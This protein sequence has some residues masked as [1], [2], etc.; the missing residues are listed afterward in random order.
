VVCAL[1]V[2]LVNGCAQSAQQCHTYVFIDSLLEQPRTPTV[3][4]F[5]PFNIPS[6]A[7]PFYGMDPAVV[8]SGGATLRGSLTDIPTIS[9]ALNPQNLKLI[10]EVPEYQYVTPVAG[11]KYP[12]ASVEV[13]VAG[14]DPLNASLGIFC[15]LTGHSD[16]ETKR[17][18]FLDLNKVYDPEVGSLDF[19]LIEE[20][21]RM[22]SSK[23]KL[24]S[25]VLRSGHQENWGVTDTDVTFLRDPFY[26]VLQDEI[27]PDGLASHTTFVHLFLNGQYWGLY[28]LAERPDDK[29]AAN[30]MG[31]DNSEYFAVNGGKSFAEKQAADNP[32]KYTTLFTQVVAQNTYLP[33]LS[34]YVDVPR[35]YDYLLL[36]WYIGMND[37]P[38]K[39]YWVIY[40]GV[41][42]NSAYRY[43]R[44]VAWDGEV[45]L[46]SAY[47]RCCRTTKTASWRCCSRTAST[48]PSSP[49]PSPK[50]AARSTR[51]TSTWSSPT[52]TGC[53][54]RYRSSSRP[55]PPPR[56]STARTPRTRTR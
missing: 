54:S 29:F 48:R 15:G 42:I 18:F 43:A 52:S 25:V 47:W 35:F 22:G 50:R 7:P 24:E 55:A 21:P 45:S 9:I 11:Q 39:N 10:Y 16:P 23:K 5:L 44:W 1:G 12:R 41:N 20:F 40:N 3:P 36:S 34:F 53:R 31:G 28:N 8:A 27:N 56:L 30:Y 13:L 49:L 33:Q 32:L 6:K 17:S 19:P 26:R 14:A 2:D 46:G 38:T 37:W 4:G 51:P